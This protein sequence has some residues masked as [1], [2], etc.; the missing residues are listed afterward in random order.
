MSLFNLAKK[1]T[2]D[3]AIDTIIGERAKF[4]GELESTGAVSING[5][6]EGKLH[7]TGEIIIGPTGKL[8][9][10]IRGGNVVVS[11][12]VDGNLTASHILEIAKSGKVHG[13]LTGGKIII[14]EGAAYRGKVHVQGFAE[15]LPPVETPP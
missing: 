11:G 1:A 15:E 13:D 14:E 5:E 6:F 8:T 2:V 9:G 12:R 10:E 4:K 3:G 7:S